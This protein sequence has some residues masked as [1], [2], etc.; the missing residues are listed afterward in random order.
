MYVFI[1]T[2]VE[3]VYLFIYTYVEQVA[4]LWWR[5]FSERDYAKTR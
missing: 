3:Q 2:Y 5:C 1:Y 4:L